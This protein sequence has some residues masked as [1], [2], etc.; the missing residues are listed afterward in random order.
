[1]NTLVTSRFT[2]DPL[3]VLDYKFDWASLT[4]GNGGSNWLATGETISSFTVTASAGLTIQSSS[5]TDTNTSVTVWLTGGTAG[6]IY[7]VVCKIV[8]SQA[9]TDERTMTIVVQNR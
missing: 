1:M 6:T 9:R 8:T 4:N 2:K 7:T 3:A 5:A